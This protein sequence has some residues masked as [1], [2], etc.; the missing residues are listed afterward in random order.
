MLNE[1]L[2]N[3]K[4]WW[5]VIAVVGLIALILFIRWMSRIAPKKDPLAEIKIDE[6]DLTY[7]IAQYTL[8]ADQLFGA[9][10]G[11]AT[12]E[13]SIAGVIKQIQTKTD[14]NQLV[15]S[16]GV[17]K[18]TNMFGWNTTYEGMLPGALRS[19]MKESEIEKNVNVYLRKIG[20]TV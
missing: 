1:L 12:D 6:S 8:W 13:S 17:R 3:K 9:M 16:Y 20:V 5:V 14:W 18:L 10:D 15:K 11:A 19:E 7:P 2:N 4:F